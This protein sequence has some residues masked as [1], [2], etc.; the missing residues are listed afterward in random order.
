M[1]QPPLQSV[2][3]DAILT[4]MSVAYMQRQDNFIAGKVFPILPVDKKSDLYFSYTK[5]DWFRDEAQLRAPSTES[6]GSGYGLSTVQYNCDVFA[7]HKDV[8]DQ[9]RANADIPLMM[10]RDAVE[11]VTSRLLLRQEIQWCTDYFTTSVWATDKTVTH[12]W[13]DY[14][15]SDPI[16][17]VETGK[18]AILGVTGFEPN[19]LVLG[20]QVF[21]QLKNH[22]DI[23]D[24]YKYTS[25]DAITAEMIAKIFDIDRILV[26]KAVKATNHEGA[27]AAYSFTHGKNALLCYSAPAPSLLTPSAGYIFAWRG[28]SEGLGQ[29]IGTKSIPMPWLE[30]TRVEGQIAFDD[31]V[32]A[33][34][35]GYFFSSVV[36]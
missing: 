8:S 26:A 19:T 15:T 18:E 35:L 23:V 29:N 17:D 34:D 27:T 6:A 2:H 36:A 16:N 33:T 7:H 24:R 25:A 13:D 11:F 22:P 30:T 9:I 14:T 21:R 3:V 32:V 1:P 20:Y 10:D 28:I 12:T 4:N 5:N 31:K